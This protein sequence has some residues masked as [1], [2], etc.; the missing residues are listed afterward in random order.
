MR[1]LS[2]CDNGP[3]PKTFDPDDGTGDVLVQG[4]VED[5]AVLPAGSIVPLGEQVVRGCPVTY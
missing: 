3:C 1:Q 5:P 4:Y 2:G